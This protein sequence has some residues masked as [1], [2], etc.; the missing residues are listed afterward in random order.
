V[1]L[2]VVALIL[3]A[4]VAWI[5]TALLVARAIRR[6]RIGALTERAGLS[7]LFGTLCVVL[8]YNTETGQSVLPIDAARTAFRVCLFLMLLVSPA[9]LLLFITNRLGG[10]R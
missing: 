3:A 5:A 6:P 10:G 9:W 8:V 2:T 1:S 7:V 4:L